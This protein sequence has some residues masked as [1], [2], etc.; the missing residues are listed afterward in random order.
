M[1]QVF[2]HNRYRRDVSV[3]LANA[4]VPESRR[5]AVTAQQHDPQQHDLAID[6]QLHAG[7]SLPLP[8]L[9]GSMALAGAIVLARPTTR[10]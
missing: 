4:L 3:Y 1:H 2:F 7:Q 8:W 5:V 6:Y 10:P 9:F